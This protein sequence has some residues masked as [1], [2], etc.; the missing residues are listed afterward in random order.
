LYFLGLGARSQWAQ[1]ISR[2]EVRAKQKFNG[3]RMI[4]DQPLPLGLLL[5][6]PQRLA[7]F[8]GRWK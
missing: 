5:G 4:I 1:K 8:G 2:R 3:A 7:L 6:A